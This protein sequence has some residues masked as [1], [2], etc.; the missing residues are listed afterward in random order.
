MDAQELRYA[1]RYPPSCPVLGVTNRGLAPCTVT[2]ASC[3]SNSM[4]SVSAR[5]R[6]S[7]QTLTTWIKTEACTTGIHSVGRLLVCLCAVHAVA[8]LVRSRPT[9][10]PASTLTR[11]LLGLSRA[12]LARLDDSA[13]VAL[14]KAARSVLQGHRRLQA[15]RRARI[16]CLVCSKVTRCWSVPPASLVTSVLASG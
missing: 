12:H 2:A 9:T 7:S 16:A 6:N 11:I 1:P 14:R 3:R 15:Q 8:Q 4:V 13:T 10:C 5:A